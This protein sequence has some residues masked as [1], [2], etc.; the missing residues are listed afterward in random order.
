MKKYKVEL[1]K[2]EREQ[3]TVLTSS[4]KLMAREMKRAMIL[5]KAD[6]SQEGRVWSD[7]A[8]ATAVDVHAMTV[9]NV[10]RRYVERGLKAALKRA[11]TGHRAATLD[12]AGEAHLIALTCSTPPHGRNQWTLQLLADEMVK[13]QYTEAISYETVR[14]VLKKNELKPWSKEEWCIPPKASAAFVSQMEEILDLYAQPLDPQRPLVCMDETSKQLLADVRE[15]LPL[16]PGQPLRYDTE[17]ERNGVNNLFLAFAPLLAWRTVTVTDQRTKLDWAAFVKDLVDV[18]FPQADV[19]TLVVDN[20]NTHTI[21]SLYEAFEPAEAHR[22]ARKID[23]HYTPKHGSWLNMAE[24]EFSALSRQCLNRRI[25]DTDLLTREVA[26]WST[27]RNTHCATVDW[28][29]TC[30]D[31]RIKLKHLY[32]KIQS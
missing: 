5:L 21:A 9:L 14:Q 15:P 11:P 7:A 29:F 1:T 12:G 13:L 26:A 31:A 22:I 30:K 32:P 24:I 17:Y 28:R 3:L 6:E 25:P 23:L 10:R 20:L 2:D 18:H 4:G 27:E 19:I 8:I 16:E